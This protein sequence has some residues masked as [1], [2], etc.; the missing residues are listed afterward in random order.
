MNALHPLVRL[1]LNSDDK[2]A[3]QHAQFIASQQL[4]AEP[5]PEGSGPLHYPPVLKQAANAAGALVRI[6]ASGGARVSQ[7]EADRRLAIC[8]TCEF[9]DAPNDGCFK[10][11]CSMRIKTRFKAMHCPLDP[12]RW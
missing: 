10:C 7:H 8:Q 3:Q 1:W 12:P 2:Q 6:A 11:A 9:Y 5:I 4:Q